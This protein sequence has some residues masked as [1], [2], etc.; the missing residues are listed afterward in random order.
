MNQPDV[1]VIVGVGNRDRGDDAV[2]PIICDRVAE[3]R[4]GPRTVVLESS[5]LELS[6]YWEATD[7]VVIVDAAGP[8]ASPGRIVEY[9]GLTDRFSVP[10]SLSTHSIDV[11]GGVEMARALD[12]LPSSLI[13]VAVEAESFEYGAPLSPSVQRSADALVERFS[14]LDASR[15]A[16]R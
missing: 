4:G 3:R 10:P 15:A 7:S 9:D 5:V 16:R 2:G 8:G 14:G 13:I 11:S 6:T 12:Q 1:T